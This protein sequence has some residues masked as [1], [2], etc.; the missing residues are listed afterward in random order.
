MSK[1]I[2]SIVT[3]LARSMGNLD[4]IVS[5]AEA[6]AAEREIDPNVLIQARL[7]PDMLPFVAQ[8]RICTDV[9]KGAA[10]RLT[11][12]ET[13]K[14]ADDEATFADIHAR[15]KKGIDFLGAFNAA[16]FDGAAER[17]VL[18]KVPNREFR[19]KGIDYLTGF[20][21]PNFYFHVSI[22]YAILRF[23]GVG[24]GK[25]DYLGG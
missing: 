8:I 13:P 18:L 25:M 4:A 2:Y 3:S 9:A 16:Q 10:A 23:N 21:L 1:D 15:L 11:G 5:K 20:V 19:F 7:R 12:S 17:D 22:A 6:F 14:W 24:L